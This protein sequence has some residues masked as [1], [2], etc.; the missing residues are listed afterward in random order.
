M[1]SWHSSNKLSGISAVPMSPLAECQ[2][3][4]SQMVPEFFH[5]AALKN[6]AGQNG[7][8]NGSVQRAAKVRLHRALC[9][10]PD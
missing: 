4:Q 9:R 5:F 10:V 8:R 2:S 7:S 6:Q 1:D 3:W